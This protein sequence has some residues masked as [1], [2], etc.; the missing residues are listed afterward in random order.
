ATRHALV[1]PTARSTLQ[2]SLTADDAPWAE[3]H[4]ATDAVRPV[5]AAAVRLHDG[6]E[7]HPGD[8]VIRQVDAD[9]PV[10]AAAV[11]PVDAAAV[12]PVDAAA[13]RPVD[14]AAV[15]PR[16]ASGRR[17]FPAFRRG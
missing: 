10:D 16:D 4:C 11:R 2:E 3:G 12:R 15:R 6:A 8:A 5:D 14:A 9:R 13:V 1:V 17:L 7:V